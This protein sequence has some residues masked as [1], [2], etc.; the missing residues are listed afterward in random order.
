MKKSQVLKFIEDYKAV[1]VLR[2]P[3]P[4]LYDPVE[5]A[6]ISGG[7]KIIEITMTTPNA[8]DII[9]AATSKKRSDCVIGVGSVT[10]ADTTEKAIDAGAQFVV[11]PVVKKSVIETC[12]KHQVAAIPGAFTPTE[13]DF[14]HEL[15]ADI[16][17]V[18]PAGTLGPSYIRAVL[19]P[20]PHLKLMPTGGVTPDN[21]SG[22]IQAGAVAVGLGSAL[23]D[24]ASL[25]NKT[26]DNIRDQAKK[27]TNKI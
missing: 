5:E 18:F 7:V 26:F 11:S 25:A 24:D 10:D 12:Q 23:V 16:I 4:E 22:W 17:K 15:G 21:V 13:I 9:K 14:A 1:A 8:L 2:L 19:A 3:S 20:M 6:L 27:L